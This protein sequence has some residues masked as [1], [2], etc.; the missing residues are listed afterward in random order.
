M[1]HKYTHLCVVCVMLHPSNFLA[2][3]PDPVAPPE[4]REMVSAENSAFEQFLN[5]SRKIKVNLL[6]MYAVHVYVMPLRWSIS[7]D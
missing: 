3:I 7:V 1:G 2:A 5:E 6:I 4:V